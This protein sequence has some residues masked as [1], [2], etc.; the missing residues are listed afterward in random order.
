LTLPAPTDLAEVIVRA[1][2]ELYAG[3]IRLGRRGVRLLGVGASGL[4]PAGAGQAPLFP[5]AAEERARRAAR[6][7]DDVRERLGEQAIT[8]ARLLRP[9][10]G[11]KPSP[12]EAS[13]LPSVD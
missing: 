1:A 13:S 11:R 9:G 10:K 3:R 7:A 8:R 2:R 6:A 12:P 4:E 5:D